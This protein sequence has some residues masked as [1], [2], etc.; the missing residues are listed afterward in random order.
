MLVRFD[1]AARALAR[2]RPIAEV[3]A[4]CGYADQSHLHRDIATFTGCA[5]G[6]LADE[7]HAA[8]GAGVGA[9]VQDTNA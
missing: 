5:P 9:F 1:G 8:P 4:V 2:G 3:A 7:L 6:A